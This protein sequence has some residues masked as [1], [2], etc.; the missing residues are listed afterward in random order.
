MG[1][2]YSIS[3]EEIEEIEEIIYE[4]R[5]FI[6][7]AKIKTHKPTVTFGDKS[8]SVRVNVNEATC[9]VSPNIGLFYTKKKL[10]ADGVYDFKTNYNGFPFIFER[11]LERI[12]KN[13]PWKI[14]SYISREY[15]NDTQNK[16]KSSINKVNRKK[17]IVEVFEAEHERL[18][19]IA[20]EI[21]VEWLNKPRI[22]GKMHKKLENLLLAAELIEIDPKVLKVILGINYAKLDLIKKYIKRNQNDIDVMNEED[23]EFALHGAMVAHTM[24][25]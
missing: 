15:D 25:E 24:S 4:Y 18:K 22:K 14:K 6:N 9:F 2:D 23:I 10:I 13:T 11:F 1:I 5:T 3:I 16:I 8:Y 17:E 20:H 7:N 12:R 21:A 19:P